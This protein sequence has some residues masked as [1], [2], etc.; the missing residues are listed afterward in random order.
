MSTNVTP[1]FDLVFY[2][3]Y[4]NVEFSFVFIT[5]SVYITSSVFLSPT[6]FLFTFVLLIFILFMFKLFMFSLFSLYTLFYI[7]VLTQH[8]YLFVLNCDIF[9]PS[10]LICLNLVKSLKRINH[11]CVIITNGD[12]S[13]AYLLEFFF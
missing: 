8:F 13:F 12:I 10:F 6:I 2:S 5:S 4:K 7:C 3:M 9:N 1:I 11:L